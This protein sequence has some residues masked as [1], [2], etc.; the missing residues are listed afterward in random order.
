[1]RLCKFAL[2]LSVLNKSQK[3]FLFIIF[4]SCAAQG[5][6]MGGPEDL[7]GP[8]VIK[9]F[10]DNEST[11]LK[12]L[13][14]VEIFFNESIDPLSARAAIKINPSFDY[15]IKNRGKKIIIIPQESILNDNEIYRISISKTIRDY[16]GN[17]MKSPVN[18]VYSSGKNIPQKYISGSFVNF[19]NEA[20]HTA[21]LYHYPVSDSSSPIH[22]V[23]VSN[24]G[25]FLFNN[26]DS[27]IYSIVGMEGRITDFSDQIRF[28]KYGMINSNFLD[29]DRMPFLEDVILY[30]DE[31]IEKKQIKSIDLQNTQFGKLNF[32]DGGFQNYLIPWKDPINKLLYNIGDTIP[33]SIEKS[34]HL[35]TYVTS[36]YKFI[37]TEINDTTPP[38]IVSTDINEMGLD[39][40]FSE[41]IQKWKDVSEIENLDLSD[42]TILGLSTDDTLNLDY[43]FLDPMSLR[44][45]NLDSITQVQIFNYNIKDLNDNLLADSIT[46]IPIIYSDEKE[47][48]DNFGS[49]M[50]E[51]G[52]TG[53]EKIVLNIENIKS[54][55]NY[56]TMMENNQY[57][58][59]NLPS[60]QYVLWAYESLNT[61]N[62]NRYFSGTWEPYK[63]AAKFS[64]Y[65]D[66][67]EIRARWI[68]EGLSMDIN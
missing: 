26:L 17:G 49:I 51:I 65:P 30:I 16:R 21:G 40:L 59:N 23:E 9:I 2:M 31:P 6:A 46:V 11:N 57:T 41:P 15:K 55:L 7:E 48:E 39:I 38:K 33:I 45:F 50:G 34:N 42:Y 44:V 35:E 5:P 22:L 14:R 62:P 13:D 61:I 47:L 56:Y 43:N 36:I 32:D 68:I 10:P 27:G 37:L 25:H 63:R 8:V 58:F 20:Y 12:Y 52:Y 24:D 29:L 28:Y 64:V 67:I 19:D 3:L 60:G 4:L 18:I 1:M 53:N 66:T 54:K